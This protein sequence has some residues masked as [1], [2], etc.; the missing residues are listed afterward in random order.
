MSVSTLLN[1]CTCSENIKVKTFYH[2][3]SKPFCY[4]FIPAEMQMQIPAQCKCKCVFNA[5]NGT[6]C[7][8]LSHCLVAVAANKSH[9]VRKHK[10]I[11]FLHTFPQKN[12]SF[13]DNKLL[14]M[15]LLNWTALPRRI[16]TWG[17]MVN[18]VLI[19]FL[20]ILSYSIS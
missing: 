18:D 5:A 1:S 16:I 9:Y 6:S 4:F 8:L 15:F 11:F 17:N 7:C 19:L 14:S 2:I 12:I 13:A 10:D 20:Q 3:Q